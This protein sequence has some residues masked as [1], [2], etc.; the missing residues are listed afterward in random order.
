MYP[1]ILNASGLICEII[2]AILLAKYGAAADSFSS[3]L[4][5]EELRKA[6]QEG[7]KKNYNAVTRNTLTGYWLLIIGFVLQLGATIWQLIVANK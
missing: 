3:K 7:Q 1:Y 2:G 6:F 4:F 5:G